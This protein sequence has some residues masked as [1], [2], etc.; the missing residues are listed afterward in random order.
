MQNNMSFNSASQKQQ[1]LYHTLITWPLA[2]ERKGGTLQK[3]NVILKIKFF[4][5]WDHNRLGTRWVIN[6]N[7]AMIQ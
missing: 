3:Q 5:L 1:E 6:V 7:G 2:S 4:H